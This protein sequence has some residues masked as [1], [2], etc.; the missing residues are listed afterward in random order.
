MSSTVA[1]G[2]LA[3][4]HKLVQQAMT[5]QWQDVPKTVQERRELLH[6]LSASASPQD[7]Q[8]LGALQQAMAESD[9]AVAKIAPANVMTSLS[10]DPGSQGTVAGGVLD[11]PDTA[12]VD[13]MMELLRQS[14]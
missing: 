3:A 11:T 14:R 1:D 10:L 5:G 6:S 12:A 9:A 13:S 8:W 4:T 7:R 2:V